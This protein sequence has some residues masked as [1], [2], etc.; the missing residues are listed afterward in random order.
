MKKPF[1]K[2]ECKWHQV[3]PIKSYYE[4]GKL[5]KKW[6]E[7]YCKGDWKSCVRFQME[8]RGQYHPDNM[9]PDGSIDESLMG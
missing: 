4:Q 3:C 8:E 6:I 1:L 7:Q 2:K 5:D 9:L